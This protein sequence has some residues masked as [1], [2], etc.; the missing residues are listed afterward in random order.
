MISEERPSMKHRLDLL[1]RKLGPPSTKPNTPD[2]LQKDT[3]PHISLIHT[4][5]RKLVLLLIG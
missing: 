1:S 3:H 2:Y 5:S 4:T